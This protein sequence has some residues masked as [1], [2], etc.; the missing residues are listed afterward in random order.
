M[1][2]MLSIGKKWCWPESLHIVRSQDQDVC[3]H[4]AVAK[5]ASG[6]QV[7]DIE[8][9][10]WRVDVGVHAT[11]GDGITKGFGFRQVGAVESYLLQAKSNRGSVWKDSPWRFAIGFDS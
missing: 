9:V 11:V 2:K 3:I 1:S 6:L 7:R 8:G 4:L 5:P 10:W